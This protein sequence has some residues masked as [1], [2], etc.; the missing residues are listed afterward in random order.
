MGHDETVM[1]AM[2]A[3]KHLYKVAREHPEAVEGAIKALR[4]F[5]RTKV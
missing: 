4:E 1:A 3:L 5:I 2:R